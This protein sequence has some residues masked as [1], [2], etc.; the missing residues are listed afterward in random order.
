[1]QAKNLDTG[2]DLLR[3]PDGTA[4]LSANWRPSQVASNLGL[5][6]RYVGERDDIDG[7]GTIH[8]LDAYTVFDANASFPLWWGLSL[9][10]RAENLFDED[11]EEI[12]GY[13]TA[14]RAGYVG[15]RWVTH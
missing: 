14:G 6:A 12:V 11:Y 10:V 8:T 9:D 3:R 5:S 15:L 13:G 1:M 4:A 7:I 2:A